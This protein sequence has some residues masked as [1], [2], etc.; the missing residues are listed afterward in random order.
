MGSSVLHAAVYLIFGATGGIGSEVCKLLTAQEGA[1]V[2]LA[3]RNSSKLEG[4]SAQLGG[5]HSSVVVDPLSPEQVCG[6]VASSGSGLALL[7][8]RLAA[9]G[10]A[11]CSG[12]KPS[13]SVW[14]Q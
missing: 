9:G 1:R 12:R 8:E 13:N 5:Q 11:A 2:V 7:H 14:A 6:Q 4:L 3:A 10:R